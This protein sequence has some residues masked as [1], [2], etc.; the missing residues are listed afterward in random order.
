[1]KKISVFFFLMAVSAFKAQTISGTIISKNENQPVP[2]VKIGV[3]K[4]TTGTISDGKG[5][6]SIDLSGLDPQQ[7]V[8]IA[9]PGYEV[10]EETVQD[11]KMHNLQKIFLIEKTKNIKAIAI[12]P[13]KLV[14]KNWGVNTKTKNVLYSVNPA[15]HQNNFLGETALAFNAKKRSKIKNINLNIAHFTSTEPVLMRYSIYSEKGGF[16]DK[17]ILDEE[18][19]V[20]LTEDMIKDGTYTLDV[21]DRDIW[22]N[23]KFFVG[24]QFLKAFNG[25]IKISAAL[26][27]TGFIRE[28][29]GDWKKM[30][31]AAPAIN[32]DV[33]MDKNGKETKDDNGFADDDVPQGWIADNSNNIQEADQSIYGK[34]ESA[35]KYM[36]LKDTDLYYEVYGEGEPLVLLHGNSGS[37]KDYYQQIP[38]LSKQYK[39]IAVDTRGQG[40]SKDISKRDFSYQ[41][42]ADDI[43]ALLD[44]LKLDK[45]NIVGWSDG[46]NTGLEFA[47]KY[48]DHL[49]KLVAIGANA[50]P[51][52]VENKLIEHFTSQMTQLNQLGSAETINERRLLKIMITEPNISKA[53]LN[54]IKSPVLIIAGDRDVIKQDHTEFISKEIPNAEMKIYKDT[55]HMVPF[56]KPDQLNADILNFLG[57]K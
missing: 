2:Y 42:F 43:K 22:I 57:K 55:T 5:K 54:T 18:I 48:P 20:Q 11:F 49:N 8:K 17:N 15:V 26:L 12:K 28:F 13:K 21:N 36:K 23:G 45:I 16:P 53:D 31:I 9:V 10:Y 30:T 1:M 46:G 41:L 25:N 6:F 37:I 51:E 32:I 40:K 24:I 56:E 35:G 33:K 7:K 44:H 52:G 39:V 34:N 3:E 14:D 38:V 4:K 29:Y 19:T 50:F 47:L 27:K